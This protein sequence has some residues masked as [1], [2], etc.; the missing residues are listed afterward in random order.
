ML[1]SLLSAHGTFCTPVLITTQA[2]IS[3][4]WYFLHTGLKSEIKT[5]FFDSDKVIFLL[6]STLKDKH[7]TVQ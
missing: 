3:S 6:K 2:L 7:R 4:Y 1:S 5:L